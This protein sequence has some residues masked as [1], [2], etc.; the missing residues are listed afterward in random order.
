V[1]RSRGTRSLPR[2]DSC[3][4]L[5]DL[6]SLGLP[7][8][9]SFAHPISWFSGIFLLAGDLLKRGGGLFSD[10]VA[11]CLV[12]PAFYL[13][14]NLRMQAPRVIRPEAFLSFFLRFLFPCFSFP[15]AFPFLI[16][17]SRGAE[18]PKNRFFSFFRRSFHFSDEVRP[19]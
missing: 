19:T 10:V 12:S 5:R 6:L 16:N 7:P 3:P 14:W 9:V 8:D 18:G 2:D 11:G 13:N 17:Q 15:E 4:D 1:S